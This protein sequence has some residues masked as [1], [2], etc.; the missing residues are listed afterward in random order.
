MLIITRHDQTRSTETFIIVQ[1]QFSWGKKVLS[2]NNDGVIVH[3]QANTEINLKPIY[4]MN[5]HSNFV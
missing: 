1:K 3:L 4:C 2:K 5:I